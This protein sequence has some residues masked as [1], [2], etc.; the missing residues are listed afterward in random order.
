MRLLKYFAA[1][2]IFLGVGFLLGKSVIA[3]T[4]YDLRSTIYDSESKVQGTTSVMLDFGNGTLATYVVVPSETTTV[5][6]L[7]Q[8]MVKAKNLTLGYQ[9]YPGLGVFVEQI[10]EQKNGNDKFWQYWVNNLQVQVAS[11]KAL[12]KAG[13]IVEWK[14][15]KSQP[16]S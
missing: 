6:F 7:L 14:F 3:P 13:D 4:T 11:D 5:F 12:L 10:G 8:E 16:V 15:I 2:I 9:V 1:A